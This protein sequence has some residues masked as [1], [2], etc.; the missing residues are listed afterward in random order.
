MGLIVLPKDPGYFSPLGD[1][2]GVSPLLVGEPGYFCIFV[3][4]RGDGGAVR[5]CPGVDDYRS[6]NSFLIRVSVVEL[7]IHLRKSWSI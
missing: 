7:L 1:L 2:G 3:M 5:V 4:N 6:V